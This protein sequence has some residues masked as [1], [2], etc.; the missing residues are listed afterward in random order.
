[1]KITEYLVINPFSLSGRKYIL[2]FYSKPLGLDRGFGQ[3]KSEFSH[4]SVIFTLFGDSHTFPEI[5]TVLRSPLIAG[6]VSKSLFF[7]K[8]IN[9]LSSKAPRERRLSEKSNN[10]TKIT[11][12]D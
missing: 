12:N 4:F 11:E 5:P 1:M 9:K 10:F 6:T 3:E 2:Y 8:F 7:S